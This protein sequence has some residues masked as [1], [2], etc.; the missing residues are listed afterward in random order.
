M[1][2]LGKYFVFLEDRGRFKGKFRALSDK[3]WVPE[4]DVI[5][6][7]TIYSEAV[8]FT[9]NLNEKSKNA[10]LELALEFN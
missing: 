1:D 6:R 7:F 9:K 2:S 8:L 5:Q 3:Y 10:E 4:S